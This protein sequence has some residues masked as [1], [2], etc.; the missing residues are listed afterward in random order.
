MNIA[1]NGITGK[2]GQMIFNEACDNKDTIITA[3]FENKNHPQ[4]GKKFNDLIISD[5][6]LSQVDKFD[7]II[8][9][10]RCDGTMNI[11]EIAKNN[12]KAVVIGTT[13]FNEKQ[14]QQIREYSK[15][16]P[17]VF[18]P[19]MSVGVNVTLE[20]LKQAAKF[21]QPDYDIEIIETHHRNKVD[22]PSGTALKMGE[23]IADELKI[24]LDKNAIYDRVGN[25]G[26]RPAGKIGFATIRAADVVG[27]HTVLF[28]TAGERVEITHK[29]SSRATFA[30][31][32]IKSALWLA[33]KKPDLYDM[34][35]VLGFKKSRHN[36]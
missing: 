24:D 26:A 29:A 18:A 25:I 6:P 33:D 15:Y 11:L 4:I 32:A 28:A 31:G 21:L 35:D 34:S 5:N 7:V 36:E 2:M 8:D 22:A 3:V 27:E 12:N 19:N 14:K 1:I 9:F 13:G 16:I 17:I 20:L 30:R 10:T 23:V